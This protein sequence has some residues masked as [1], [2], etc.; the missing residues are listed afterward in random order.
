MVD[1]TIDLIVEGINRVHL[2]TR[3]I[4]VDFW[5]WASGKKSVVISLTA[6][7]FI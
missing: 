2:L 4:L 3:N 6:H 1:L 7:L 5:A